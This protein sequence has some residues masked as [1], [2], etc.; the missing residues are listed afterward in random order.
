VLTQYDDTDVGCPPPDLAGGADP[1]VGAGRW[2]T[3]VGEDHV[4]RVLVDRGEQLV[5]IT[6]QADHVDVVDA[7]EQPADTVT[8]RSCPRR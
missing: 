3:D 2:Y 6:G 8:T 5:E 1:F 7:A 4:G